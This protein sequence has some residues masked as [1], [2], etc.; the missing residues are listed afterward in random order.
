MEMKGGGQKADCSTC[1][2][3]YVTWDTNF[4]KGCRAL[5]FKSR[6]S[7]G[8]VVYESSGMECQL[9]EPRAKGGKG[10][11]GC[12]GGSGGKGHGGKVFVG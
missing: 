10:G 8:C 4:P 7:P 6:T 2:H 9:F 5:G 12:S 11:K 3:Y 1:A